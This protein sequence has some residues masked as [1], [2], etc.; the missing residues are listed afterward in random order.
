MI[1]NTKVTEYYNIVNRGSEITGEFSRLD[2]QV[3]HTLGAYQFSGILL[4]SYHL[5][6][7]LFIIGMR[8][9]IFLH[10]IFG[11]IPRRLSWKLNQDIQ[12]LADGGLHSLLDMARHFEI[13][14][15]N[16]KG[17]ASLTSPIKEIV[18]DTSL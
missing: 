17:N 11:V 14:F 13:F 4:P 16:Q 3:D 2:F 6:L 15:L 7:T 1:E 5:E 18:V 12:Y 10:L 8:L 9:A